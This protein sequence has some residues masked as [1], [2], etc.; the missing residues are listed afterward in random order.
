MGYRVLTAEHGAA[1]LE[2]WKQRSAEVDVLLTDVIMPQMSGVELA[3]QL[4]AQ[5]PELRVL[6]MSGYTD[7]MIA[8]HGLRPGE[9]SI[10]EKPFT[11]ESLASKL[12][13]VLDK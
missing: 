13:N 11:A 12:R 1:A 6:F 5:D 2:I 10:L 7:D 3:Q 9:I 8:R 4:R